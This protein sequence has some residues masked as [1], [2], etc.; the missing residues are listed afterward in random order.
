MKEMDLTN[1]ISGR[2]FTVGVLQDEYLMAV[3]NGQSKVCHMYDHRF[4][5]YMVDVILDRP[6][7]EFATNIM[8]AGEPRT[9][10]STLA[11]T[12]ARKADADFPPS[13]VGF[14]LDEYMKI[15]SSNPYADP[16]RGIIPQAVAD[17]S[18]FAMAAPKHA[19]REQVNLGLM[20]QVTPV[21][22]TV[23]YFV[24]PHKDFLLKNI[25]DTMIQ[26][27]FQV[28]TFK[29]TRG[30]CEVREAIHSKFTKDVYWAPMAAFTFDPMAKD[31]WW[32]EYFR[33]KV[34]FVDRI[35]KEPLTEQGTSSREKDLVSQR[36]RAIKTLYLD[37]KKAGT[38]LSHKAIAERMGMPC[39][40]VDTILNRL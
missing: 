12:M 20:F 1:P 18:G 40:T 27:W 7:H 3:E 5:D 9:G 38:P 22:N 16:K 28:V 24:L 2:T 26:Y 39:S 31:P 6:R 21:I 29:L 34:E 30:F 33:R 25:R 19:D 8:I 10:K 11:I 4:L 36:N 35:K 17:E 13:K 32:Q 15:F 37:A 14:T 23:S